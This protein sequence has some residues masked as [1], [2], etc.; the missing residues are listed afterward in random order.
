MPVVRSLVTSALTLA[1]GLLAA[2]PALAQEH[3]PGGEANLI[4]PDL[5]SAQFLGVGGHTLL[6]VGLVVSG[7]GLLFGL[8]IYRDLKGM[9]VHR[10][11]REVSELIYETCQTYL[12]QQGRFLLILWLFIGAIVL[13]YFGRLAHTIDPIDRRRRVR[14]PAAE[15]G[16]DPALL[17]GR[18]GRLLRRGLVRHPR[19][20]VRQLAHRVCRARGQAVSRATRSRSRPA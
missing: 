13:L 7:F 1:V 11:M 8:A 16:G 18:H 17:A 9:P 5:N 2:V 19:Q 14:L 3:R 6:L 20:H 10:S 12:Q 4:L 15:G